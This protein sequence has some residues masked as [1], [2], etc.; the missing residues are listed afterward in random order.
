VT[1]PA[2]P[3]DTA[4]EVIRALLSGGPTNGHDIG[5]CGDYAPIV[6]D[7]VAAQESGG[8]Q[9][10]AACWN[11]LAETSPDLVLLLCDPDAGAP[12]PL[13]R[14]LAE[15][16]SLPDKDAVEQR[17]LDRVDQ[18]A[19]LSKAD[20]MKLERAL[21]ERGIASRWIPQWKAAIKEAR[22][23]T[24]KPKENNAQEAET[25]KVLCQHP[26]TEDDL[27]MPPGYTLMP[28]GND[29]AIMKLSGREMHHV[30]TGLIF[31]KETGVNLHTGDQTVTVCWQYQGSEAL[32]EITIPRATLSDTRNFG[33]AIGGAGAIIHTENRA[34]VAAFLA[35][36]AA[37]NRDT[38]PHTK[39]VNRLGLGDE[40][41]ILVL[42]A[43][44]ASFD[45]ASICAGGPI[46]LKP[47]S[48]RLNGS[49][50]RQDSG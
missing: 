16:E 45:G 47:T 15:I 10:V 29:K 30:Y 20:L 14:L 41:K 37:T 7:L 23:A 46:E 26:D 42:P 48:P 34:S 3:A 38:L 17:L 18:A 5:D 43:K 24:K 35:E 40:Q 22:Q 49:F 44:I 27:H 25:S 28:W 21:K 13:E 36:F 19:A 2:N 6:Q 1:D 33:A 8:Q 32:H 4:R 12:A 50:S 11:E 31:I 39:Q 9:A